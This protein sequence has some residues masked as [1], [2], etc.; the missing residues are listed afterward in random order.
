VAT[1]LLCLVMSVFGSTTFTDCDLLGVAS[2]PPRVLDEPVVPEVPFTSRSKSISGS[3]DPPLVP[4]A[5]SAPNDMKSSLAFAFEAFEPD[6]SCKV[7][8]VERAPR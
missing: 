5:L 3:S 4:K 7:V 6:S 1:E 8:S 2:Q